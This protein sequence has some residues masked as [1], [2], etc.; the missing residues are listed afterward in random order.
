MSRPVVLDSDILSE[1]SRGKTWAVER[2]REYLREHGR[3]TVTAVSAFE[4]LRGYREAIRH[5]KHFDSYLRV[6][7]TFLRSCNVLPFDEL[8]AARAAEMWARSTGRQRHRLG[9]LLIAAIAGARGLPLA[10]RNVKDFRPFA[11]MESI[12]IE[13]ADWTR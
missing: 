13:L 4:R 7:E 3:F 2:A 9:D 10:T 12:G 5:G 11:E 6:F 8:A 1:L